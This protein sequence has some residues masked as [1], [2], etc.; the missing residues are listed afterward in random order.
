MVKLVLFFCL[1][2]SSSFGQS[3]TK[4]EQTEAIRSFLKSKQKE[5]NSIQA[6]FTETTSNPMLAAPQKGNGYFYFSKSDKIRWENSSSQIIMLMD[7]K[8]TQLYEKGKLIQ[9]ATAQRITAQVQK[10]IVGMISGEFMN[11]TDYSITF[12][13][14]AT[15]YKLELKPNNTRLSKEIK[16]MNLVFSRTSGL[17]NSLEM[18][19]KNEASIQYS[20]TEMK[21]N[22]S[23]P[24]TKFTKL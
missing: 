11:N 4:V 2:F 18:I 5:I 14:N 20:F 10:M 22:S 17:L 12:F 15:L 6:S 21:V 19:Q 3:F 23:V 7:G 24:A 16:Q 9:N 1:F 13:Q 8:N